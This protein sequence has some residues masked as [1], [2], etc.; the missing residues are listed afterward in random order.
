MQPSCLSAAMIAAVL[1]ITGPAQCQDTL[2]APAP[3]PAAK[4]PASAAV[5][6]IDITEAADLQAWGGQAKVL[7]EKWYPVIL[8][9]LGRENMPPAGAL[10]LNFRKTLDCPASCSGTTILV[11]AEYVRENPDDMG[12]IVH[13]LVHVVQ[14]YPGNK[15]DM[16]WLVEGIADYIRFWKYEPQTRQAPIDPMTASYRDGYRVAGAFIAWLVKE[17]DRA[18]V[19]KLDAL[20]RKGECDDGAFQDLLG[21]DVNRLWEDFLVT[22]AGSQPGAAGQNGGATASTRPAAAS[23]PDLTKDPTLYI[24]G[25]A[26]LDTQW[27][28][29]YPEVIR[30]MIPNTMRD[31]FRLLDLYPNYVFN[32]SGANRYRMMQ[33]YYPADYEKVKKYVAEDRWFPC[34]SSAEESDVNMPSAESLIRQV[35]YGNQFFHREFDKTSAEYMLPDCFG[36]PASLPTILAHCGIEGF[37]TQKLTWGSAVGIPFNVGVWEGLDGSELIA[38]LNCGGYGADI[39]EDLSVNEGWLKRINANGEKSGVFAD[40][41]YY[42][43]GDEGGAPREDSVKWL[44]KC[45][46]GQGPVRVISATAERM[47]LD[48]PADKIDSL[49]RYQGD[50]LLTEHS[51]G[52]ITSQAYMKRWNRQNEVLADA[53]ERASVLAEWLG[54]P[55][56]P[57]QRLNDAWMLVMG[58]QFH[59][60]LPGTSLPKCYEYSWNDELLALNQFAGVLDHAVGAVASGL[61]TQAKGVPLVVYNPLSLKRQDVVEAVVTLPGGVPKAVRVLDPQGVEVPAQIVGTDGDAVKFLFLATVPSVGLA[62]YDVQAADAPVASSLKVTE[63]SLENARYRITLDKNGDVAGIFDK[64]A[65]RELL[66]A[67]MRLAFMRDFPAAWPAWNMDWADVQ[68]G[69]EGHVSGPAAVKIVENGPARVALQVVRESRDSRFVQTV[70][71]AAGE[72]GNRVEF[73]D[74]I[75]WQSRE[76]NLKAVFPLSVA[77]PLATYNWEP[78]T[79]QRGNNDPKKYEVPAQ[80]WFDLTD[81]QG[82]YG[83]TVLTGSKYGSDKPDDRTPRLTLLRTPGAGSFHEQATQDWGRH[84]ILYGVAGHEGDWRTAQTD[85]QARR[86]DQ[87]LIAFQTTPHAGALGRSLSLIKVSNSRVNVPAVKKAEESDEIIVRL[88]ELDGRPARD[89]RVAFSGPIVEAR[90]VNGQEQPVG[91]ARIAAGELV[92]DLEGYSLRT[93]A[94]KLGATPAQLAWPEGRPIPLTYDRCV[95]STDGEKAAGGFDAEGRSLPAEMFPAEIEYRGVAFK[96]GPATGG[97]PNAVVCRGQEIALP[98]GKFNRLYLLAASANDDHTVAFVVDGR[99]MERTMRNWGGYIGSWDN[100]S[101]KKADGKKNSD[102]PYEYT[103]LLPAYLRN[104]AVAWYC[105]HHHT[106][107]GENVPYAFAYLFAYALDIPPGAKTLALPQDEQ[108]LMLAVTAAEDAAAATRPAQPLMDELKRDDLLQSPRIVPGGGTFADVTSVAM[109]RCL[110]SG[111]CD[112]RYT[113]DGSEPQATSPAYEAPFLLHKETV[114]KARLFDGPRPV[115]TTTEANLLV[116]DTTPPAVLDTQALAVSPSITVKFSEPLDKESAETAANYEISC[117]AKVVSAMLAADQRSVTLTLSA[118][119][120]VEQFE[121]S[122]KGV[123]DSSPAGNAISA[124][125]REGEAPAEPRDLLAGSTTPL[126]LV[127]CL[128]PILEIE[129]ADLDGQGGGYQE[130]PLEGGAPAGASPWTI[131]VWLWLDKQ[132]GDHTLIAGFGNGQ[133]RGGAQRYLAKFPLGLHFWGSAIDLPGGA[134]LD[135]GRW[136]MLTATYDGTTIRLY[137]DGR[138]LTSTKTV[139]AEAAP[140]AKLG[141]PPPWPHGHRLAGKLRGFSLWNSALSAG[142]VAGLQAATMP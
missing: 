104:D 29:D 76:C 84:E 37:S 74:T 123:R 18:I 58:G 61:D 131:N 83:V 5:F 3:F 28:W 92:T 49:P 116:H 42:G 97:R 100:R 1:V 65:R 59:D 13:E 91:P 103:G 110:W 64:Q 69:P 89:V 114:V 2:F 10:A 73:F 25:Y 127:R 99:P 6:S 20:L 43:T 119:P 96:L 115:G 31:N 41:M 126:L 40:Y 4:Q 63:S 112:I 16:G 141:P 54:G 12:M 109:E 14:A 95:T 66:S 8:T 93:F 111:G 121:L 135:L 106:A 85:W 62:V 130:T 118:P 17:H 122:I 98:P 140:V 36:F 52:S 117:A 133:D 79:I 71:L 129:G 67:P 38:A 47:F 56:Y 82:D 134:S 48:I 125:R 101:W 90:E 113:K 78:G 120:A 70:R 53:A 139:F 50:L 55:A 33:E 22:Q 88:V 39:A 35:L 102:W 138:E 72:S 32:F 68:K 30:R 26:H 80:R 51:A 46:V 75:D 27:R 136:Q 45:V 21:Q 124:S 60:I 94:V 11:N 87:P 128:R 44:E 23:Q 9:E 81:A 107:T 34:G 7:C 15:A 108:V 137:K 77:N 86:L 24:V 105:S 132:P 142:A 57:Q 19:R